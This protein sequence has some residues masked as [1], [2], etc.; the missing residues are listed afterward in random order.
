MHQYN[1]QNHILRDDKSPAEKAKPLGEKIIM[2][3]R[4]ADG[5]G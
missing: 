4:R 2:T 3:D 1:T 5:I